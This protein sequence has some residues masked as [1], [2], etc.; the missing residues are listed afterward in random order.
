MNDPSSTSST[1]RFL[2]SSVQEFWDRI[3]EKERLLD[4]SRIAES[5]LNCTPRG[6]YSPS[7]LAST[8][9]PVAREP[10]ESNIANVELPY[11]DLERVRSVSSLKPIPRKVF[12]TIK[13]KL[14]KRNRRRLAAIKSQHIVR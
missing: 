1:S 4:V 5:T 11:Q 8:I 10:F 12:A 2:N 6:A 9:A 14:K 3:L 13:K 7:K